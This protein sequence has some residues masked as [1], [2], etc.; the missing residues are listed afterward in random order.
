[1]EGH[2]GRMGCLC[3]R[4]YRVLMF[5]YSVEGHLRHIGRL[6]SYIV[7]EGHLGHMGC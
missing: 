3:F 7:M 5:M 4:A 6:C 1:M 2:L